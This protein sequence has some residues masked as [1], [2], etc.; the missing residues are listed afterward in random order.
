MITVHRKNQNLHKK[1]SIY[2]LNWKLVAVLVIAGSATQTVAVQAG[3]NRG[4]IREP[5][6]YKSAFDLTRVRMQ[7]HHEAAGEIAAIQ[8]A[9]DATEDPLKFASRAQRVY[10]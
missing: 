5:A 8:C 1:C 6:F 10:K 7:L 4:V 2:T 9:K 3:G